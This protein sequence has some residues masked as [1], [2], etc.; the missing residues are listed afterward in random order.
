MTMK[1]RSMPIS[2]KTGSKTGSQNGPRNG[3]VAALDIGTS[4]VCCLI[5]RA[6]TDI[7]LG[8]KKSKG[9]KIIGIGHQVSGGIRSGTIVDL[10]ETEDAIRATVEAAEQMAG[11]NIQGV[12]V[13]LSGGQ[14]Q[15]RL[16]AYEISIAGHEIGD[17]DLRRILDPQVLSNGMAKEREMVHTI[18]VGYSIDGNRGVRDPRGMFG[19]KLGVNMHVINALSGP[20]RNLETS[21]Q[22]CYLNIEDK[23]VSSYASSLAT[24]ADDETELGVT[25]VDMGGG[26]T[27]IA[28]FFDGELVHTDVIP[29]G[30]VHVTND[31]ARGLS[32]PL[33]QAERMKTLYGSA[34]ASSSDDREIIQVPLVGEDK[35]GETNQ[36]PRS[37]LV[38]IIRPRIEETLEMVRD[39]L[40][41]AG[42]DKVAGKR[43]VLTGG[44]SQLPGIPELATSII[45]KQV[46]MGR[47]R[48]IEG[49]PEAIAGPAFATSAGLLHYAIS[50]KTEA[51]SSAYCPPEQI[52]GRSLGRFSQ[53]I[54]ENL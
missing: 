51:P 7:G 21:V 44:A 6:N 50:N 28:V 48:A 43:I 52:K 26:T 45:D 11:E 8:S 18:P 19:E 33:R 23:V 31:I 36:V 40:Q 54:R 34:L 20:V 3:L 16:I 12:V 53:W 13:N 37:M 10:D 42:F 24:L 30:G 35:T 29:I 27:S 15:S 5:A 38:G 2:S 4:K 9:M 39:R 1:K 46:R 47:P 32:S 14:P 25:C 17:A 49:M 22:R 41:A